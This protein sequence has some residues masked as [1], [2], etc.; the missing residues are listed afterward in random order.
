MAQRQAT[1]VACLLATVPAL[2][3]TERASQPGDGG[4]A[5]PLVRA[6]RLGEWVPALSDPGAAPARIT[7]ELS[8][9]RLHLVA[10]NSKPADHRSRIASL[11]GLE[12]RRGGAG[13]GDSYHLTASEARRAEP[14]RLRRDTAAA[15]RERLEERLTLLRD[16]LSRD[17]RALTALLQRAPEDAALLSGLD[18]P[19]LRVLGELPKDA[20]AS[21]IGKGTWVSDRLTGRGSPLVQAARLAFPMTDTVE[22]RDDCGVL[23]RR[24]VVDRY[25]TKR[26]LRL[27]LCVHGRPDAAGIHGGVIDRTLEDPPSSLPPGPRQIYYRRGWMDPPTVVLLPV[28]APS[29]PA[30][31][32]SDD[33][34]LGKLVTPRAALGRT[35][36]EFGVALTALHAL[37]GL[38]IVADSFVST[39]LLRLDPFLLPERAPLRQVLD[40]VAR[41]FDYTWRLEGDAL[42][43]RHRLWFFEEA[44]EITAR[45]EA[46][47]A[48]LVT[49]QGGL[50]VQDLGALA[51]GLRRE[52]F[53]NLAAYF[54]DLRRVRFL[55]HT[56]RLA[57][58]LAPEQRE[59]AYG[60]AG[61]PFRLLQPRQREDFEAVTRVYRPYLLLQPPE[62]RAEGRL[63][64]RGQ[65]DR[66]EQP[67]GLAIYYGWSAEDG[68]GVS[69]PVF[70]R[71]DPKTSFDTVPT[72]PLPQV[73]VL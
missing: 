37:S 2:A 47:L 5:G 40:R 11:L 50:G 35:P 29:S 68:T 58:S 49:A 21:L 9:L 71:V 38:D 55:Y 48:G 12:W 72:I 52:Q 10:G 17:E 27:V 43:F 1:V 60:E 16:V 13:S 32:T 42:L 73:R 19:R 3:L 36:V 54:A 31:S 39:R 61:L 45:Q 65:A 24:Q 15:R 7:P 59:A 26:D 70:V 33:S 46:L 44:A 63:I 56:L 57:H 64:F 14:A 53:V 22:V 67:V 66:D 20:I 30:R 23:L 62:T 41:T 69:L 34:R 6:M 51:H 18:L 28:E 4:G 8:D 25:T